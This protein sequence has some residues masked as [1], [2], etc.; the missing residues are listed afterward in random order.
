M[1]INTEWVSIMKGIVQEAF[2][3]DSNTPNIRGAFIDGQIQLMKSQH[4]TTMD[5]FYNLQYARPINKYLKEGP[6]D[7]VVVLA[8]DDYNNVPEAKSMTQHKRKQK[9]VDVLPFTETD[10]LPTGNCPPDWAGAMCNR[11]FKTKLIRRIT[12]ILGTMIILKGRQRLI[13]DFIGDPVEYST[14]PGGTCMSG[15]NTPCFVRYMTGFQ[16]VGEADCKMP[17]SVY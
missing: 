7:M 1:G 3:S 10:K 6:D 4:V 16:P 17:R 11:V 2:T 5:M 9:V 13:V 12:E 14:K 8:F 15:S